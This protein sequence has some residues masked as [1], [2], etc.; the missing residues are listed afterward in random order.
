MNEWSYLLKTLKSIKSCFPTA[1]VNN[2]VCYLPHLSII[3]LCNNAL[4]FSIPTVQIKTHVRNLGR[5]FFFASTLLSTSK[6]LGTLP[7]ITLILYS[8]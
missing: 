6:Y 4:G 7:A 5:I 2:L 3:S 8:L 1:S